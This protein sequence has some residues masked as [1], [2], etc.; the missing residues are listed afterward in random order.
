M[1][2]EDSEA[3]VVVIEDEE[4]EEEDENLARKV[5]GQASSKFGP[6]GVPSLGK[7]KKIVKEKVERAER[8]ERARGQELPSISFLS[9]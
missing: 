4:E 3:D 1:D 9:P 7:K 8:P 6:N 5:G 2:V